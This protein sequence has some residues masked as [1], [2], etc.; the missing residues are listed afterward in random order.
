MS[1]KRISIPAKLDQISVLS[2]MAERAA[3]DAGFDDRTA[4]LCALAVGEACENIV[5]HGYG[6]TGEGHVE[7]TAASSDGI[8]DLTIEDE[9]PPFNPAQQP[10]C[11]SSEEKIPTEG[12]FGLLIIH[13]AMDEI[14]YQRRGENNLLRMRKASRAP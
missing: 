3:K 1:C 7:L 11:A 4:Y 10:D 2:D 6:G 9:A 8:L 13:N 12:G 14:S 5:K